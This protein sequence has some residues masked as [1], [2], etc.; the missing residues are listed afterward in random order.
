MEQINSIIRL[1]QNYI[2]CHYNIFLNP[3]IPLKTFEGKAEIFF[4]EI[5]KDNSVQL[6]AHQ[7]IQI[8]SITQN[9]KN[10]KYLRNDDRITIQSDEISQFPIT[11]N[12]MGSLNHK[13]CG[14]FYVNDYTIASQFEPVD[15]RKAFPCTL[16]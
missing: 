15:C 6:H 5:N 16:R 8:I 3:N 4:Q 14:I 2:P 13:C 10:L 11:I 9:S 1:P 7:S 12:Y